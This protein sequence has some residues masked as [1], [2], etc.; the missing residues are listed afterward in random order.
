M[1]WD[2]SK[3]VVLCHLTQEAYPHVHPVP[4][5]VELTDIAKHG[6]LQRKQ[7]QSTNVE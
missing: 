1:R 4:L 6:M 5:I 3:G 2:A 7:K